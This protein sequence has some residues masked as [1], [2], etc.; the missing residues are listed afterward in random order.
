MGSRIPFFFFFKNILRSVQKDL[1]YFALILVQWPVPDID[2]IFTY[3][4][5][6]E[7]MK[8]V[9]VCVTLDKDVIPFSWKN[10][11][12]VFSYYILQG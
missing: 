6:N 12:W 5:W 9:R 1:H 7:K 8:G 10:W 2:Q 3:L 4:R 11:F